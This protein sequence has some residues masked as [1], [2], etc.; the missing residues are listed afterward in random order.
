MFVPDRGRSALRDSLPRR[1]R[2]TRRVESP[3]D[4]CGSIRIV[5]ELRGAHLRRHATGTPA[6]LLYFA[7]K[8]DLVGADVPPDITQTTLV[9]AVHRLWLTQA[10][11][12]EVPEPFWLRFWPKQ[13]LLAAS[14]KI[15]GFIAGRRTTVCTYAM[16]NNAFPTLVGGRRTLPRWI[17]WS[18]GFLIGVIARLTLDRICYAS[19]DAQA[20][21]QAIPFVRSVPSVTILELPAVAA[22][23]RPPED[24]GHVVFLGVLEARKGIRQLM[25]AWELVEAQIPEA[26]LTITGPGPLAPAVAEWAARGSARRYTGPVPHQDTQAI[27]QSGSVVVAPSMPEGRWREQIG[28]PIKEALASGRT[29]VTTRQTALADWLDRNGHHVVDLGDG[30]EERLA[31]Q[32]VQAIRRPLAVDV[33]AGSLPSRDGRMVADSWLH[34]SDLHTSSMSHIK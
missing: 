21:Y 33:V 27:V 29:V 6:E 15:I 11:I 7:A 10:S 3:A 12:L 8:Y 16:E 24:R 13:V 25:R 5:P 20:A 31:A 14:F 26:R 22:P 34:Q 9:G 28:L 17:V 2:S 32:L 1:S 4:A 30:L 19:P 18:V 23:V